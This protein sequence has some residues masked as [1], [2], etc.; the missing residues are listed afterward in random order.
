M[1]HDPGQGNQR[2]QNANPAGD[3]KHD[4]GRAKVEQAR[5]HA[6]RDGVDETR[7]GKQTALA[8]QGNELV[9][10]D[11]EGDEVDERE[12]SLEDEP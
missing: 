7:N 4:V 9:D 1:R 2:Q 10:D 3:A 12:T 5:R 11:D 6:K 8:K